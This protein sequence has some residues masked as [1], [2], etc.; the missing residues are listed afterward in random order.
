MFLINQGIYQ[1]AIFFWL[2]LWFSKKA[3]PKSNAFCE[4]QLLFAAE[5]P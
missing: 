4:T 2:E 3:S 1:N 5:I